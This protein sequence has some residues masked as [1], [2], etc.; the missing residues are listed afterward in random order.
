MPPGPFSLAFKSAVS[1]VVRWRHDSAKLLAKSEPCDRRAIT[2]HILVRQI[3]K[4]SSS[5]PHELKKSASRVKIMLV[6]A[7]MIGQAIDSFGQQRDL[8]LRRTSVG[9]MGLELR[10]NRLFL[11][12]L[13]RHA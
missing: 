8:N 7:K 5:L 12:T 10:D 13:K 9:R 2:L 11:L 4:E 3:S 1:S 6:S